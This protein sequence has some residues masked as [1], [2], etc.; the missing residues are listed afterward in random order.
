MYFIVA[1][2]DL[3][4]MFLISRLLA[5]IINKKIKLSIFEIRGKIGLLI[6]VTLILTAIV[7]YT[8]IIFGPDQSGK[9]IM[10]KGLLFTAYFVMLIIVVYVVITSIKRELDLRSK[11]IQ[12]DSLQEYTGSL[13]KLYTDMRTFRHDYIN[14]LSSMIGYIENK[15]IESL[16]RYFN[17]KILP[18]SRGIE[19]NNFKLGALKN[20][21]IPEIKG[22]ISSK[23]IRAQELNIDVLLEVAEPIYKVNIDI[24][25]LSRIVGILLDNAIEAAVN[26]EK[27]SL[28]LALIKKENSV[29]IVVI[30]SL[31]EEVMIHKI[32]EKGFSTKG[33]NRGIG[34]YNLKQII[35][36][37][38]NITID[39]LIENGE[40]KQ[41]F[42]IANVEGD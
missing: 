18:L 7:F 6:V 40:F 32:Y 37:Y 41:L 17:D 11:Q 28:K 3:I 34:L 10:V 27:P 4:F 31:F 36:G 21:K 38:N 24:I 5:E 42:E 19:S 22:I 15:D 25:D 23:L 12:F 26:C 30:N 35:E 39:T 2:I 13:E 33:S 29:L 14:I 8:N 1:T 9:T 20:L 16:E